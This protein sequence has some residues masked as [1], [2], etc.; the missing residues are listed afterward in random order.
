[1]MH[2][3]PHKSQLYD[4]SAPVTPRPDL[5]PASEGEEYEVG[6]IQNHR[7]RGRGFQFLTLMIGFPTHD[8]K[9]QPN[10]DFIDQDGSINDNFLEYIKSKDILKSLWANDVVEDDNRGEAGKV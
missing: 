1:M 2:T 5:T 9:W 3:V 8:A 7:K 4:T 6:S 10:K